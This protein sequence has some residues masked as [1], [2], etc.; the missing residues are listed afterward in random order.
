MANE[1]YIK[2][3]SNLSVPEIR[4]LL[5]VTNAMARGLNKDEYTR[6]LLIYGEC[7]DRLLGGNKNVNGNV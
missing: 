4:Q 6:I 2:V 7:A 3:Q 5:E 1:E